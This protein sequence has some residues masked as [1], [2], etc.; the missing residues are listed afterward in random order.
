MGKTLWLYVPTEDLLDEKDLSW[1][2]KGLLKMGQVISI[3]HRAILSTD[4]QLDF[5]IIIFSDVKK[6]GVRLINYEYIPDIKEAMFERFSRGEFFKR[7]IKDV[8]V[9][10]EAIGDLTGDS[11]EYY[12]MTFD[13]FLGLQV[14]H[15]T[16]N[17]F[18]KDKTLSRLFELKS[19]SQTE[20]FG[21]IKIDM[22][23]MRKSYII[24]PEEEK[25]NPLDYVTQIAAQVAKNYN[26]RD[27][28]GFELKDSFSGETKTLD[29]EALKKIK[30]E[31][32]EVDD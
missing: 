11:V 21:T 12:D 20:K 8:T 30:I 17:F 6:F 1:S 29:I 2:E 16:K 32:P 28:Q 13:H 27:L 22:E 4:A 3:V 10:P 18:L 25:I 9:V 24:T 7:S 26:Y 5:V 23:F 19:I 14:V 31:L 15:R